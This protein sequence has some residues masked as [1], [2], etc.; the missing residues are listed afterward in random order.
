[1]KLTVAQAAS[2]LGTGEDRVRT[3]IEDAD[4]PAQKIRGE[5]RVNRTDLLEWATERGIAVAPSVFRGGRTPGSG[6]RGHSLAGALRAGGVHR[7]IAGSDVPAILRGLVEALPLADAD[8]RALLLDVLLAR[9]A[10]GVTPVGDGIAIPHARAPII[11][12]PAGAVV[13]LSFLTA[14]ID[15]AAPDGKPV[16]TLFLLICPT[17]HVHLGMLAELAWALKDEAFRAAIRSRASEQEIVRI[18]A[19]LEESL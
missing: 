5:F 19:A 4:L 16:D 1:M 13:A 8:D 10:L 18:A 17:I 2:I 3:W 14:P 6:E 12:A 9:G 15:L 7:E 11:L